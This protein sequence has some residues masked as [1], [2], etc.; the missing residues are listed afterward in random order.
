ME[1]RKY[2]SLAGRQ[3]SLEIL[4]VGDQSQQPGRQL[5]VGDHR[6]LSPQGQERGVL[7]QRSHAAATGLGHPTAGAA[8]F[9]V[10]GGNGLNHPLQATLRWLSPRLQGDLHMARHTHITTA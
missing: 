9:A 3:Q 2:L 4:D 10:H 5:G 8:E 7:W 6:C 1:L